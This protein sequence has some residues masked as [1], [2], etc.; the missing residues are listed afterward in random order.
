[1]SRGR[2]KSSPRYG[3]VAAA[4][5]G[6]V[7][8]AAACSGKP[9]PGFAPDPALVQRISEIR[10]HTDGDWVCPGNTIRVSYDAVLDDGSVIP[11]AAK[12]DK[13]HPPALHVVFLRRTS[14]EAAARQDGGWDTNSDPVVSATTGF[15][16]NAFILARPAINVSR[17]VFPEYS[18]MRHAFSF[19][20]GGGK[21]G[22]AGESGPDVEVRLN[23]LSSP[24]YEKLLVAGVRV[25]Y[26]PTAYVFA[27]A[28]RVPPADWLIVE[29]R[30]GPGGRGVNGAAGAKGANGT[31]GCPAGTG[32]A[33]GRGGN[34]GAGGPGGPGGRVT[35]MVPSSQPLLAGMLEAHSSGGVGGRG[36]GPGKGGPGGDG[37]RGVAGT[38][39]CASGQQGPAG[40]DGVAGPRGPEGSPGPR[41]Q[42]VTV[43]V[44]EVF[45]DPRL[46]PLVDYQQSRRR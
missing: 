28:D 35:V 10:M 41:A 42:I 22:L 46:G 27:D 36:G 24:Y 8:C 16:L 13:N 20:G 37:G 12:Y 3:V 4:L 18:C 30:G 5:V 9:P 23:V 32:G 17:V 6:S 43:P 2:D 26:A 39:R 25:G 40:E 21:V 31:D 14:P 11:F 34:G 29:S 1:M 38:R 44:S 15:R 33:G 45:V 7:A 19:V